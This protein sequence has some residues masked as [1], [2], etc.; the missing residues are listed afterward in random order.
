MIRVEATVADR[1]ESH[2]TDRELVVA[3]VPPAWVYHL[4]A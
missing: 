1:M 4:H 3:N 2:Q